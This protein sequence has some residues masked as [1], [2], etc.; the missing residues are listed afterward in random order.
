MT[1]TGHTLTPADI[2]RWT[3]I[4]HAEAV[5]QNAQYPQY[6]GHWDGWRLALIIDDF[7]SSAGLA[8]ESGDLVLI[9]P[10]HLAENAGRVDVADYADC[11]SFRTQIDTWIPVGLVHDLD[12]PL[13]LTTVT[14]IIDPEPGTDSAERMA[15]VTDA[16]W[17]AAREAGIRDDDVDISQYCLE[18]HIDSDTV[19]GPDGAPVGE[20]RIGQVIG[21]LGRYYVVVADGSVAR[22]QLVPVQEVC[23]RCGGERKL[24]IDGPAWPEDLVCSAECGHFHVNEVADALRA[25]GIC[26]LS[27]PEHFDT[28]W[29][30]LA[31]ESILQIG[32]H[33]DNT[34]LIGSGGYAVYRD[35][36]G[37]GIGGPG[38]DGLILDDH[39]ATLEQLVDV[40]EREVDSVGGIDEVPVEYLPDYVP[41][42][43]SRPV[44]P[45]GDV[46]NV[47][48]D[49]DVEA[50]AVLTA[51]N[52]LSVNVQIRTT[53]DGPAVV[54]SGRNCDLDGDQPGAYLMVRA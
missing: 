22:A 48:V 26:A 39:H 9:N 1:I 40:I 54:V 14:A 38:N 4:R 43:T 32:D 31:D 7:H 25:R 16:W 44:T 53:K 30:H 6:A 23:L 49:N 11:Y 24:G 46:D 5:A 18:E 2:A 10:N 42:D 8:F 28:L 45:V 12:Q 35:H 36:E 13:D 41:A 34:R 20:D 50:E 51:L 27:Q 15:E 37:T 52:G 21:Y 19:L 29:V 17:A 3:R 33:D 47:V